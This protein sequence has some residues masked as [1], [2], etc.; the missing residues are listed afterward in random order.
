MSFENTEILAFPQVNET[1]RDWNRLLI[2]SS[3]LAVIGLLCL[4]FDVAIADF[5]LHDNLP[6]DIR[7]LLHRAEVF[8]HAYGVIAILVTIWII[9]I[10]NRRKLPRL[11]ICCFGGGLL[12]DLVKLMVWRTRPRSFDMNQT[13]WDSFDGSLLIS[14]FQSNQ[15]FDSAQHS[16][17]SAH[18]AVAVGLAIALG[19]LYPSAR[20]WFLFL[21]ALCGLNRTDGG[22]HFAS[23]VFWG[24]CLGC[25]TIL[26]VDR[27]IWLNNKLDAIESTGELE[28]DTP[29][30]QLR[31]AA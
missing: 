21:S 29:S 20:G 13:V 16:F 25:F 23:D 30:P 18:T 26:M 17:P 24:A 19:R 14:E 9:D 27:S 28:D 6:G 7:A 12:A 1:D 2:A 31:R 11:L 4:P 10:K 8:G 15:L 3:L 22:A 5:F